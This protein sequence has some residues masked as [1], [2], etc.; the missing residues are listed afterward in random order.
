MM[1]SARLGREATLLELAYEIEEA[2]PFRSLAA[3][4][5]SRAVTR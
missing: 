2:A 5:D 3:A 4:A 1:F